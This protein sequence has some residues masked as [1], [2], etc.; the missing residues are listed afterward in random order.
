MGTFTDERKEKQEATLCN[1][2][3]PL[4]DNSLC[5]SSLPHA[6]C[7]WKG[8]YNHGV[9]HGQSEHRGPAGRC[10]PEAGKV[11]LSID[12]IVETH[13]QRLC[14]VPL[15]ELSILTAFKG[16]LNI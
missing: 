16:L 6:I 13:R 15:V 4:V 14:L 12:T 9:C 8:P 11:N 3:L 10:D 1:A 2:V 5:Y 7:T